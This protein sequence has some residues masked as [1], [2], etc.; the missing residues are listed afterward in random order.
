MDGGRERNPE[1]GSYVTFTVRDGLV[2]QVY[3]L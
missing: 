3:K 1:A 2:E